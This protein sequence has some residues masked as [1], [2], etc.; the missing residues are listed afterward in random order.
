MLAVA[1]LGLL[2]NP[3]HADVYLAWSCPGATVGTSV[4][5]CPGNGWSWQRGA[6]GQ[7]VASALTEGSYGSGTWRRWEDVPANQYVYT[8]LA[9]RLIGAGAGCPSDGNPAEERYVLK[10]IVGPVPAVRIGTATLITP[11]NAA[12]YFGAS[13]TATD[14]LALAR[15]AEIVELARALSNDPDRIYDFV[16]HHVEITWTYGLTKGAL[17]ALLDRHGTAFDQADLMI[18]LLRQAGYS[19]N[20]EFGTVTRTPAEFATWSGLTRKRA[21]CELLSS[22]GIPARFGSA[23]ANLDC[24]SLSAATVLT[25]NVT[26]AHIWVVATL[27]GTAYRFDP[28]YKAHTF[29]AGIDLAAAMGLTSGQAL[30]STSAGLASGTDSG[31]GYVKNLNAESLNTTLSN[32][33]TTLLNTIQTSHAAQS[34]EEL[35]GSAEIAWADVTSTPT[36]QTSLPGS[37][38]SAT[39]AA[40]PDQ[41]RTHLRVEIAKDF[42]QIAS[43][44]GLERR[45]LIDQG[46]FVDEI[47]GRKLVVEPNYPVGDSNRKAAF[48]V[49]LRLNERTSTV[50]TIASYTHPTIDLVPLRDGAIR[51]TVNHP[52]AASA[53]PGS[54]ATG[55]DYLDAV[56]EKTAYL[57]LPLTIIHGWGQAGPRLAE[58]WGPRLDTAAPQIP[59]GE[60]GCD[61]CEQFY[62]ASLG[63]ARREQLAASWLIQASR[64]A[65]LHADMARSVYAHHHSLG[66]STADAWPEGV[67]L[68]PGF[69]S[70]IYFVVGDSFDR[71]DVDSAFSLTSR[72]SE[73]SARRAAVA[74]IAATAEALEGSV[75]DQVADL[76]DTTSSATRFEWANRPPSAEDP[77]PTPGAARRFYRFDAANANQAASLAR[78][79]GQSSTANDGQVNSSVPAEPEIGNAEMQQRRIALANAVT[80][81]ARG[82][83]DVVAAEDAFLGPGQR[84]GAWRKLATAVGTHAPSQQRGGA[85][86]A[87]RYDAS[88][89]PVE[90]AHIAVGH[91]EAAKGGGGGAQTN[92]QSQ[93]DP[94]TAADVLK[95]RFADRS[96][97]LGVDLASGQLTYAAPAQIRSGSGGFP[98]ELSTDLIWRGGPVASEEFGPVAHTQPQTPW[99][100]RW[101]NTLNLSGSALEALGATDVRA[102]AGTI[103]A[104]AAQQDI[105]KASASGQ[106]EAAALLAG[107][108]W[109]GQVSGNVATV[110]VG[111]QS[112]QFVRNVAGQWFAPG[113][114]EYATFAQTGTRTKYLFSCKGVWTATRGWNAAGVSFQMTS[115]QGDTQLFSYWANRYYTG[116][117]DRCGNLRGFRL[118][119]WTFPQGMSIN[120]VYTPQGSGL[121]D[122]FTEVNNTLGRRIRFNYSASGRLSGFD[123]GL[124]GADLRAVSFG[125]DALDTK[126]LSVTEATGAQTRFTTSVAAQ[127][128][129]LEEVF[130]ADDTATPS[131]RYLYD[132]AQRVKEARDAVALQAGPRNP[133][134]FYLADGVRGERI[135]PAGGHYQVLYDTRQRPFR[136]LDELNRLTQ[137]AYDGR[138]RVTQYTYPEG[139]REQLEYDARN[140]VTK[141]TRQPKP[142]SS[143]SPLVI[144]ATWHA[145]WNKPLSVK[146]A[147]GHITDFAYVAS[148]NGTSLLQSATRP[149]DADGV[150][151]VYSFAYNSRGQL[152]SATD[153]TGLV[154]AN[155]Y[156][157]TDG[158]LLTTTLNPGGVNAVTTY[159]HDAQGDV[160]TVSDPRGNATSLTFDANRRQTVARHHNGGSATALLSAEKTIY[161]GLGRPVTEQAGTAFSGTNVTAW[162]TVRSLTYTPVGQVLTESNG[163]GNTTTSS[164][165]A[166]DRLLQVEDPVGRKTR[167]TVDLAGQTLKEMRAYGTALQQD[168]A[169]YTYSN[170]GQRL[171]V[172]DAHGN[173]TDFQYDGHDRLR[174]TYFPHPTTG[175]RCTQPGTAT[176]TPSCASGQTYDPTYERYDLDAHGN[177]TG[178]RGRDGQ[179]IAFTFDALNRQTLK[180]IPGGTASDVYSKYDLAGRPQ[181][182]K[183]ANASGEGIVYGYDSAQRLT[184]E[185][186]FGR[187]VSYQYDVGGN[188]TRLI[189]PDANYIQYTYDAL[190]RMDQVRENGATSGAG[191]LADYG[192]DAL[193]RRTT[194]ARGNGTAVGYS[195]DLASRLTGLTQDFASTGQDLVLALTYTAASQLETRSSAQGLFDHGGP[196]VNRSYSANK[197]NQYSS[198][199]GVTHTY[200]PK[201]NLTSD[202]SRSFGYDVENRLTSVSGSASLALTYDPLGRLRQTTQG[203]TVTQFLYDGD[204]LIAEYD[205]SGTVLRRYA[206]GAGVDEPITWYEGASLTA[207][208]RT[209]HADERGSILAT[210]NASGVATP[211]T[212]G[213]YG[214][215]ASWSGPRFRYTGQAA[216]PE[217]QLYHYK[218][219]VYDPVLGRFLQTD[220]VGYEDDLNLYAYVGNDPLNKTDPSGTER[221]KKEFEQAIKQHD[222]RAPK[223]GTTPEA[224]QAEQTLKTVVGGGLAAVGAAPILAAAAPAVASAGNALLNMPA[225]VVAGE[226]ALASAPAS[227]A[228]A[229]PVTSVIAAA[230]QAPVTTVIATTLEVGSNLLIGAAE[231]QGVAGA[232]R[233]A[234]M[235]RAGEIQA[236]MTEV[237]AAANAAFDAAKQLVDKLF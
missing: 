178:L 7:V 124:A 98:Y 130:D 128:H 136:Y 83:Y 182:L 120:F 162:Q 81:Y 3:A 123:N 14:G 157:A 63:D 173:Q 58:A 41:Y 99:T 204:R 152:L 17:G 104:F 135:D 92:H 2:G 190:N 211:Y 151:P 156:H 192:Y 146:D 197:L 166:M 71:I 12:S 105:Y 148:G 35:V 40:V 82:G 110:T 8:C 15:P 117:S 113:A 55:G 88:G 170:N 133:H 132:S 139:D 18:E 119:S 193:S 45:R 165:D 100:T 220:P 95:A 219:R 21:A 52:Y 111:A 150:R 30:N 223:V 210:S 153:P 43:P 215:P 233:V 180:D 142:G 196:L 218:A 226:T 230:S 107:A 213:P 129:R 116:P 167:F 188:R 229:A 186:S 201:G 109:L 93:Y 163:A 114:L 214:E 108:W 208:R 169:T 236:Q 68:E 60:A 184:S 34:I 36:R 144:E 56:V 160:A 194:L 90:I 53:V 96:S 89:D 209:L 198:V 228:A 168:Y 131:L 235:A 6:V 47:Y 10:S 94:S 11:A 27:G 78:V 155:S 44:T 185:T 50:K 39:W 161:D 49:H 189:W 65:A 137:A 22:G 227:A 77:S 231:R 200:D 179:V 26:S 217:V 51:L 59:Y 31:V 232:A 138:G 5:S 32:Y 140:Q 24:A 183:F 16:R 174:F 187:A 121:L 54:S 203:S 25:E 67:D 23:S 86:V 172:Q 207:D 80:L 33:G 4:T 38:T 212:Y 13:S 127:Q 76:P 115:A 101:H 1:A 57:L 20:F 122:R 42:Q 205:G 102:A 177:R 85:L 149:A 70:P 87:T 176:G 191:L 19:A 175:A 224:K 61:Q 79:E 84:G 74:A 147:R 143:E 221:F 97:A 29:H 195:H 46:L 125:F 164:Y 37:A 103:A 9:E 141:L 206:H 237:R 112:R 134:V 158:N 222:G 73:A 225:S 171:T 106:R 145:T 181:W 48:T 91:D 234:E 199:G 75:A 72:T 64:A 159:T 118:A 216:L 69:A 202:G 154:I 126:L 28:A 66:L 62:Y